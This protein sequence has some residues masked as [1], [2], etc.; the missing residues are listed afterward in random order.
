MAKV[1]QRRD[2][3]KGTKFCDLAADSH[4]RK[5]VEEFDLDITEETG[6][7]DPSVLDEEWKAWYDLRKQAESRCSRLFREGCEMEGDEEKDEEEEFDVDDHD[8]DYYLSTGFQLKML[9]D[10][11]RAYCNS[12]RRAGLD[13][14]KA[15]AA[16]KG[17]FLQSVHVSED[18]GI[19]PRTV[20]VHV[21]IF[22][23]VGQAKLVDVEHE[24][25]ARARMSFC[26]EHAYIKA[27]VHAVDPETLTFQ[28][29][30]DL[31]GTVD[32]ITLFK[33]ERHP[34]TGKRTYSLAPVK[35]AQ[36]LSEAILGQ[37]RGSL[38]AFYSFYIFMMAAGAETRPFTDMDY[39][40]FCPLSYLDLRVEASPQ[41]I[42]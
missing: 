40:E 30:D 3:Q 7:W 11:R 23:A 12:L 19:Q 21:R 6:H 17:L 27:Q 4:A 14:A 38:A 5:A 37:R 9:K 18:G 20:D 16:A 26:E 2:E 28:V 29:V 24:H 34:R 13:V 35:Q 25:H 15:E 31:A 42:G 10:L 33:M 39:C 32:D 8:E 1:Q 41:E 22:S 36:K